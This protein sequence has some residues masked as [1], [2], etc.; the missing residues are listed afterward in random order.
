MTPDAV[1]GVAG[2]AARGDGRMPAMREATRFLNGIERSTGE[3]RFSAKRGYY[4]GGRASVNAPA[5]PGALSPADRR[6]KMAYAP[7]GVMTGSPRIS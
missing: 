1:T 3:G 7:H 2:R 4:S 5:V 6:R